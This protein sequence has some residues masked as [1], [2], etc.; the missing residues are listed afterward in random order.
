MV[1]DAAGPEVEA[2]VAAVGDPRVRFV[3]L[4]QRL[5]AR[6]RRRSWLTAATLPRNL[7]YRLARGHWLRRPRRRRRAAPGRRRAA[8]RARARRTGSRWPTACSRRTCPTARRCSVGGFPPEHTRFGWQGGL[9]HAGLRFFAR[10]HVAADL[11]L[12][13]DWFRMQRMLRA[14]VRIGHLPEVT[15]D[16]YPSKAWGLTRLSARS[17]ASQTRST[18]PAPMRA[19]QRQREQRGA[20]PVRHRQRGGGEVAEALHRVHRPEV[21]ARV[22]ARRRPAPPRPRRGG[23][24]GRRRAASASAGRREPAPAG[25]R[26][27]RRP[28]ARGSGPTSASRAATSSSIAGT[29]RQPS[30]A[31]SSESLPLSPTRRLS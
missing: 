6:R 15:C 31:C 20:E 13:G 28:A 24:R 7:A 2:A 12:P 5:D 1:G 26:P 10:E 25:A 14:G 29:V 30:A 27:R 9:V 8:A 17:T 22:D 16:Y 18:S 4:T 3:N 11:G 21:G 19:V 23:R